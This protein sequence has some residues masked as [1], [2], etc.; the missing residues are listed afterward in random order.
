MKLLLDLFL[1]LDLKEI[2]V[3]NCRGFVR[4]FVNIWLGTV[5]TL[6]F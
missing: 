2:T 1:L 6:A 4:R 5:A 3:L